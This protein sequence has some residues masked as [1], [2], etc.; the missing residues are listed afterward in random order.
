MGSCKVQPLSSLL[1]MT[2]FPLRARR[3]VECFRSPIDYTGLGALFFFTHFV[4]SCK[5]L[6]AISE[7]ERSFR[8]HVKKTVAPL[9]PFSHVV[10]S[11]NS[12]VWDSRFNLRH[13]PE[14]RQP[15]NT[16]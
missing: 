8:G 9:R 11:L 13:Q 15:T 14:S 1:D 2:P 6:S 16:S 12:Q 5:C 3:T 4:Q 7:V 10:F